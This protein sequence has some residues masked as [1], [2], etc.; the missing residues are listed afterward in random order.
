[1]KVLDISFLNKLFLSENIISGM[2][3]IIQ[4]I[5]HKDQGRSCES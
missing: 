4:T 1:M 2:F 5:L 3:A